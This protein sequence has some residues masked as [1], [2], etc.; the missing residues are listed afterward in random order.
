MNDFEPNLKEGDPLH[1]VFAASA[2]AG[3]MSKVAS[4]TMPQS[5]RKLLAALA[6]QM[7]DE[8]M[9]PRSAKP[10]TPPAFMG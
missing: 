8:M 2:L 1:A 4:T 9:E 3:I 7:A 6:W 10:L 5:T